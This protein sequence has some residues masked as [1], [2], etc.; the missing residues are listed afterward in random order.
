MALD[1]WYCSPHYLGV[2]HPA[3]GLHLVTVQP[4]VLQ[5]L[6]EQGAAHVSRVVELPWT[7]YHHLYHS[8]SHHH[9]YPHPISLIILKKGQTCTVV[10][11]YLREHYRMSA[12]I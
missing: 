7:Q 12:N 4:P 1:Q 11:Q 8:H 6:L 2:G 3:A 5:L 9:F 10:I